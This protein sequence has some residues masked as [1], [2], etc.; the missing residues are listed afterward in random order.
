MALSLIETG[1]L[2]SPYREF[3]L[4]VP[5]NSEY[6]LTYYHHTIEVI[7]ASSNKYSVSFGSGTGYTSLQEGITYSYPNLSNGDIGAMSSITIRNEGQYPLSI[8]LALGGGTIQDNRLIGT[9]SVEGKEDAPVYT[10]DVRGLV[11]DTVVLTM[12][13]ETPQMFTPTDAC[14]NWI[15][16]NQTGDDVTLYANGDGD[17]FIVPDLGT[18]ASD[19]LDQ[20]EIKA[21]AAGKIVVIESLVV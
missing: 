2:Q 14:M 15:L 11:A 9:V 20:V 7:A 19:C 10:R 13:A 16:Q 18:Y 21:K 3:D 8:S 5:V 12:A 4:V 17:G 6:K 1:Q